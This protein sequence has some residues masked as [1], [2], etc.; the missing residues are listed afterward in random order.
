[1]AN[2]II[3]LTHPVTLGDSIHHEVTLRELTPEDIIESGLES[4]RAVL[5]G[6]GYQFMISPT[7]MGINTLLRQIDAI[8]DFKGPF[9]IKMLNKLHREDFEVLNLKAEALDNAALEAVAKR[10]RL[11]ESNDDIR[12]TNS[13]DQSDD[14]D[15]T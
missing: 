6:D 1:M 15:A 13:T 5:T 4:E 14:S 2:I 8:G 11:D 3:K 10:G 9:T 7:L 12:K